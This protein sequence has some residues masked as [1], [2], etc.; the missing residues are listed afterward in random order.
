L[1]G[2]AAAWPFRASA[3][4]KLPTIG[5]LG[6]GSSIAASQWVSAFSQRLR[7]LGLIEGNT[8]AI[9]YRWAEGREQRFAE[10]MAEFMRLKVDAILTYSNAAALA[11]KRATTTVPI[12]FAA[13]GDPVGTGL[14]ASISR[15]GGNITG[16]S[17][18]QTDLAGKRIEILREIMPR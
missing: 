15:P 7:E 8:I 16:L 13:A 14:I 4:Q 9:E 3:Q 1:I 11:A 2:G 18:L 17:I 10:I 12:V 6:S 5:W